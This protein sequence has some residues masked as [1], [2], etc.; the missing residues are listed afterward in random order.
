MVVW[1]DP[2]EK[3]SSRLATV[4]GVPG[5]FFDIWVGVAVAT[6]IFP[7]SCAF[8]L[9]ESHILTIP[10]SLYSHL[11]AIKIVINKIKYT[12]HLKYVSLHFDPKL[13]WVFHLN[14]I[15]DKLNSLQQK[16]YRITRVTGGLN[17]TVKKDLYNKVINRILHY[18]H[19]I[20]YQGR[21]QQDIKLNQLQ[22]SGLS[23]ITKCYK[24]VATDALQV[25]AGVT[26][27]DIQPK[28]THKVF[29]IKHLK[30]EI[31]TQGLA[32]QPESITFQKPIVPPWNR[33]SVHWS[34]YKDN[35]QG[36]LFYTDGSK[37]N[38]RVGGA[39][40]AYL[41]N[42]ETLHQFFRFNDQATVYIA[43]LTAIDYCTAENLQSTNIIY[44]SRSVL[45]SLEN[46][47]SIENK[48]LEIKT[49]INNLTGEIHLFWIKGHIGHLGNERADELVKITR[50]TW[51]SI[52]NL[53]LKLLR[54]LLKMI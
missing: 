54:T 1:S 7:V 49:K 24:T 27:I 4:Q 9:A 31:Q 3:A 38:N 40:V 17:P 30:K 41:N 33:T 44:G 10:I 36:T 21:G 2:A 23:N 14:S 29:Q 34:Y 6:P 8:G 48:I 16:L 47:N 25:L 5:R 35:L 51:T 42:I 12:Q 20:R 32:F 19:E 18:G 46:V 11:P 50:V 43:E 26:P 39:F 28:H 22:R 15:Q 37:M 53:N 52:L 13:N 45:I